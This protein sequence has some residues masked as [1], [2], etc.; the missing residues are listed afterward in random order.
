MC[1]TFYVSEHEGLN[2]KR[3][4]GK[5]SDREPDEAQ[6]VLIYPSKEYSTEETVK[7]T[8]ISIPQ[9]KKTNKIIL[10]TP[11]W[12]WGGEMG[13]NEKGVAIGNEAIF[14]KRE[15]E[16][17][18]GLIGMDLLRLA[19]ERADDAD[20]AAETIINLNKQYGQDGIC[21]YRDK[22][23]KYDNAFLITDKEKA[24][25]LEIYGREWA[26]KKPDK[27][28]SI[29]NIINFTTDYDKGSDNLGKNSIKKTVK[30]NNKIDIFKTYS[31][32]LYTTFAG[33]KKRRNLLTKN[34]INNKNTIDLK[35]A[36]DLLRLHQKE[37][38]PRKGTN[39]D[40]CM[41][42]A[43][44][45]IRVSQSVSSL[46]V[47][48]E[49][50][51]FYV[52]ITGTGIPCLSV[53]QPVFFD[54]DQAIIDDTPPKEFYD[55][56]S[57]WWEKELFNRLLLFRWEYSKKIKEELREIELNIIYNFNKLKNKSLSERLIFSK[58]IHESLLKY[59]REKIDLLTNKKPEKTGL[60][61]KYYWKKL[62]KLNKIPI[63]YL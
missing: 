12:I 24:I 7:C 48:Y 1:D 47:E 14:T 55:K 18:Q 19:L 23:L 13:V 63:E 33:G 59:Y 46:V 25:I 17:G 10:S 28:Q 32:F 52:W 34:I 40:V 27:G 38:D 35:K 6:Q 41:H 21:G 22:H 61:Y 45:L 36:F 3:Y 43:N 62:N 8:Y 4:F 5:N 56:K 31:D 15:P 16:K 53:F 39:G 54:Y 44:P 29:S 58:E 42:A 37:R 20:E 9:A 30:N 57:L 60:I 51:N 2:G 26:M 11:F 50:D 49:K